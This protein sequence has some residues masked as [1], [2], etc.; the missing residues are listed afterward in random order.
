MRGN[1]VIFRKFRPENKTSLTPSPRLSSRLKDSGQTLLVFGSELGS[2]MA[3][4]QHLSH[5]KTPLNFPL[6]WLFN[7]DPY[8]DFL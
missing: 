3:V 1:F 8:N 4:C 5:K 2:C 7:K 6:Y